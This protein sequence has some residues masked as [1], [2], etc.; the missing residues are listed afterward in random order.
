MKRRKIL[1]QVQFEFRG[2]PRIPFRSDMRTSSWLEILLFFGNMWWTADE[3]LENALFVM[4]DAT[5][6]LLQREKF[7]VVVTSMSNLGGR[8]AATLAGVPLVNYTHAPLILDIFCSDYNHNIRFPGMASGLT[9]EDLKNS[10]RN[11][12]GT[13]S[14]IFC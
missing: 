7:D 1:Q 10:F 5:T 3:I 4:D 14:P 2:E 8:K 6:L 11:V 13:R 12:C 9:Q